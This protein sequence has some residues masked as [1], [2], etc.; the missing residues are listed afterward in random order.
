MGHLDAK[1][2]HVQSTKHETADD[3]WVLVRRKG[4]SKKSAQEEDQESLPGATMSTWRLQN[5]DN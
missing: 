2:Q 4:K 3:D 1:R 5:Q